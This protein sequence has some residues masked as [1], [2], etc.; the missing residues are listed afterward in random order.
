MTEMI[1]PKGRVEDF[2]EKFV[3]D[4]LTPKFMSAVSDAAAYILASGLARVVNGDLL[5]LCS[6]LSRFSQEDLLIG[7]R[8]L[9]DDS[10]DALLS[11]NPP[12]RQK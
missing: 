4:M 8:A 3:R 7:A 1:Y 6:K 5:P 9:D 10:M 11:S 12:K 2:E